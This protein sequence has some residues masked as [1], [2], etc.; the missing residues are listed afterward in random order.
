MKRKLFF[1]PI[2]IPA[3]LAL[4]SYVVMEL[5]NNLLPAILHVGVINFWQAMGIFILC[6]ILFGFGKG[7]RG[8]GGFGGGAPW[9]RNKMEARFNNMTPEEKERFKQKMAE[10]M[11]GGFGRHRGGR[12]SEWED[13]KTEPAKPTE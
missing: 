4:V 13:F 5:W 12:F 8:F 3:L 2:L 6:K 10:R 11:C 1:L 9:M 7:G